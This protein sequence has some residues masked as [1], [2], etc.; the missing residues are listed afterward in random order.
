MSAGT[1]MQMCGG[2]VLGAVSAIPGHRVSCRVCVCAALTVDAVSMASLARSA[3]A[4]SKSRWAI[5]ESGAFCNVR[6]IRVSSFYMST[7]FVA[8]P[9]WRCA[10]I[11]ENSLAC[12]LTHA[13]VLALRLCS[14]API[15]VSMTSVRGN[16]CIRYALFSSHS[17]RVSSR[18][19]RLS[20]CWYTVRYDVCMCACARCI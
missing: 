6:Q 17:T 9:C 8:M 10:A 19:L 11:R 7:R 12:F 16:S 4:W 20:I 2:C 15:R 14:I 18:V 5:I 3:S 13:H 1:R